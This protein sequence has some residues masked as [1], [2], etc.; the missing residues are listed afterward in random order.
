MHF[1]RTDVL[2]QKIPI[3]PRNHLGRRNG[4]TQCHALDVAL[5]GNLIGRQPKM[6]YI[7]IIIY[8]VV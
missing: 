5:L 4:L 2:S 1:A 8:I 6:V 7:Y 3:L